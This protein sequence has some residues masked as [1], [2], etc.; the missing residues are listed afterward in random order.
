MKDI[1]AL[2]GSDC[3]EALVGA[4]SWAICFDL[5]YGGRVYETE[6]IFENDA[7]SPAVRADYGFRSCGA[8]RFCKTR[9]H[10]RYDSVRPGTRFYVSGRPTRGSGG[11]PRGDDWGFHCACEDA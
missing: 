3:H 5:N 9:V 6:R 4:I 8:N 7:R 2:S 10:S 11:Q 1:E